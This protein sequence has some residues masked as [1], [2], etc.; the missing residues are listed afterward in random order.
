MARAISAT[1]SSGSRSDARPTKETP[2]A[3]LRRQLVR[4]LEREPRLAGA[5]RPRERDQPSPFGEEPRD[6]ADLP[7]PTDQRCRRGR[8]PS[9]RANLGWLDR[10]ARVLPED[11]RFELAQLRARLEA[12]LLHEDTARVAIRLERVCLPPRA[13]EREHQLPPRALTRGMLANESLELRNE[14]GVAAQREPCLDVVFDC[15]EARLLEPLAIGLECGANVG[16]RRAAPE[17]E[18]LRQQTV[19]LRWIAFLQTSSPVGG[20]PLEAGEV[21]L[22]R[23]D[24]HG[25]A[26]PV[27]VNPLGAESATEARDVDLERVP[28]L[29]GRALRPDGV[30]ELVVGN[31]PVRLEQEACEKGSRLRPAEGGSVVDLQ[32][33]QDAKHQPHFD[34]PLTGS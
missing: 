27:S 10:Q 21:E 18:G 26:A 22:V 17:R 31:D 32:R 8:Q 6:L 5:A 4:G 34:P 9:A 3:K 13:V 11:R 29:L 24:V 16:E 33:P 12:E 7:A 23:L 2:S 20:E 15:R 1:T 28:R 30:D 14:L 19:R 25:V